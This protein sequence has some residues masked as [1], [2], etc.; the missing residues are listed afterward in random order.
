MRLLPEIISGCFAERG[1]TSRQSQLIR[2]FTRRHPGVGRRA[3]ES[4]HPGF[5]STRPATSCQSPVI[6]HRC[7]ERKADR[8]PCTSA[9]RHVR[10]GRGHRRVPGQNRLTHGSRLMPTARPP[11]MDASSGMSSDLRCNGRRSRRRCCGPPCRSKGVRSPQ[12]SGSFPD[13]RWRVRFFPCA[14]PR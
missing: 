14:P 11:L 2:R 3:L 4:G 12:S 7:A 5:I 6:N 9:K 1:S 13:R 10:F 8:N